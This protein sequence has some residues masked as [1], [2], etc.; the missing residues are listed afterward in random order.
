M[1]PIPRFLVA[2]GSGKLRACDDG[3]RSRNNLGTLVHDNIV[4][5]S[6]AQPEVAARTFLRAAEHEGVYLESEGHS[7]ESGTVDLP[8][9]YRHVLVDPK[10]L[11]VHIA[12]VVDESSSEPRFQEMWR[13]LFVLA[14]AAPCF[15]RWL[16][17]V[18]AMARRVWMLLRSMYFDDASIQDLRSAKGSAQA[19]LAALALTL[20][21]PFAPTK[22][23]VLSAGLHISGV[24]RDLSRAVCDG[25]VKLWPEPELRAKVSDTFHHSMTYNRLAPAGASKMRCTL[26]FLMRETWGKIGRGGKAPIIQRDF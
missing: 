4:P 9:A 17:L 16:R 3:A 6:A 21:T 10:L 5:C 14:G 7:L 1:R 25:M 8:D 23:Q 18:M 19:A 26:R 15:S 22:R 12:A 2:Q 24:T 11:N 13:M 20:G